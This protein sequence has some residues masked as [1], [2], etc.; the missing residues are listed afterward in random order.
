MLTKRQE[1]ILKCIVMEYIKLAKPVGSK[2][3]CD[4]LNC[5]SAT[6]RNEMVE[7]EE[8]GLLEKTHTSSGRVPSEKGYRYYVDNLMELKELNGEDVFKLQTIFNNSQL[9]LSDVLSKSLELISD[10][11]SYTSIVLDTKSHENKLKEISVVPINNEVVIVI[12][13]TDQGYVEHKDV[14][15]HGVSLEEVKKTVKLINELII[16]TPIDEVSAKLEFEIKPI[17]AK[18][19][20]QHEV[21][22]NAF[23]DVFTDISSKNINV[24]GKNNILKHQE[25]ND[26]GKVKSIFSKLDDE[27]ILEKIDELEEKNNQSGE[28]PKDIEVYIGNENGVEPDVTVIKTNY[29]TNKD[30][31][32]IAIVGPKRMEYS[33]VV[34]LLDYIKKQ[35]ER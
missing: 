2:L 33:K 12:G 35:I 23:Y 19:V 6:V 26:L 31:G 34:N 20:K 10:I 3:I 1:E 17:I 5:S 25:F 4:R 8:L 30:E 22:Y 29:K 32:T 9:E 24:V 7:L 18:Y 28:N 27:N 21:L 11:T 13:V 15:L 16:G 14:E